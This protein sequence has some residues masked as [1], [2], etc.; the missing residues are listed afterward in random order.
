MKNCPDYQETLWL[1]VHGEL[2]PRDRPDWEDHLKTCVA[3]REERER[4][5]HLMARI[6]DGMPL[7]VLSNE[8]ARTLSR[9]IRG[10]LRAEIS[11]TS[12]WRRFVNA[13]NRFVPALAAAILLVLA[14]T[15][16]SQDLFHSPTV[17]I[18]RDQENKMAVNDGEVIR[19]LELLEEMDTLQKLVQALEQKETM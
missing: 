16:F 5:R 9:S 8:K 11:E 15:W 18:N 4:V 3:C 10:R 12:W 13:P 6:R 14:V 19:N 17:L 1:D 7:P 2:D